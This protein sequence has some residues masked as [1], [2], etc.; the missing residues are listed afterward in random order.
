MKPKKLY[1]LQL[2]TKGKLGYGQRGGG[3]FT[4]K[5]AMVERKDRLSK[6]QGIDSEMYEADITWK[7]IEE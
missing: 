2:L 3:K 1:F 4:S 5:A 7:K 6:Y